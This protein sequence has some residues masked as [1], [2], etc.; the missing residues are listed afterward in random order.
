MRCRGLTRLHRNRPPQASQESQNGVPMMPQYY[1]YS[2]QPG[3]F[4][5]HSPC[6]RLGS[7]SR[8]LAPRVFVECGSLTLRGLPRVGLRDSPSMLNACVLW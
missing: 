7:I 5:L 6:G 8:S 1:S 2:P 4:G 3:T